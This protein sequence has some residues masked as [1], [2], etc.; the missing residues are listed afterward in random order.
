MV[1]IPKEHKTNLLLS[2]ISSF[3]SIVGVYVG[4]PS[5]LSIPNSFIKHSMWCDLHT[6]VDGD[7]NIFVMEERQV[8][9]NN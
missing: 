5:E 2:R 4:L 8:F 6:N 7:N 1:E 3:V 9:N